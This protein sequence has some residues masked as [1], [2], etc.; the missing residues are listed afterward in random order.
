MKAY[1]NN[2]L[3]Y[4]CS[5]LAP[6]RRNGVCWENCSNY[7][8]Y[9]NGMEQCKQ[10]ASC[11]LNISNNPR[12]WTICIE[13]E[14]YQFDSGKLSFCRQKCAEDQITFYRNTT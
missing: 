2:M 8:V 5:R 6:F 7:V 11:G 9:V 3:I 14:D 1:Q 13:C 4:G 10:L 12:N